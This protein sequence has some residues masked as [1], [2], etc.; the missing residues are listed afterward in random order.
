MWVKF[1]DGSFCEGR[2]VAAV[3]P[4]SHNP[5]NVM[6]SALTSDDLAA[7]NFS[8]TISLSAINLIFFLDV[9]SCHRLLRYCSDS[10]QLRR[11]LHLAKNH[12]KIIDLS[13]SSITA[14]RPII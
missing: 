7:V 4:S 9:L 6:S 13:E 1:G 8:S 14:P 10:I 12:L 2:A 5:K 3:E 11:C